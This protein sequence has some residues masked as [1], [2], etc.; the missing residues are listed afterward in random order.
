MRHQAS[1]QQTPRVEQW[2]AEARAGS[3]KAL[4]RLLDVCR[5]YLLAVAGQELGGA[6]RARVSPSDVVQ[7]TL[8]EACLDFPQFQGRTRKEFFVWLRRILLHNLVNEHRRHVK[9][10]K[11]SVDCEIPLQEASATELEQ[12]AE[13]LTVSPSSH[14]QI[15]ERDERL[16]Q[17]LGRLPDHYRQALLG[18]TWEGL[19]FAQVGERLGCS[20]EAARKL[21]GRATEE[22]ARLLGD[23]HEL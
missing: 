21:W 12:L 20:A 14:I 23:S 9:T 18:H 8:M 5:P 19:K 15:Q 22:L 6:L 1:A 3:S 2:V 7:D 11:R 10:A 16:E 13:R 4:N 17:A